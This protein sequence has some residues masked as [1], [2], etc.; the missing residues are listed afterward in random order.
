[1]KAP[2]DPGS[3][4]LPQE[5]QISRGLT[6]AEITWYTRTSACTPELKIIDKNGNSAP[7]SKVSI[8]SAPEEI[9]AEQLDLGF[10]K[11]LGHTQPVLKHTARLSGLK[12]GKAYRFTAGDSEWDWWGQEEQL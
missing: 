6:C 2:T 7:E 10:M 3:F 11:I 1:V 4:R 5:L 12:P 8:S 9:M